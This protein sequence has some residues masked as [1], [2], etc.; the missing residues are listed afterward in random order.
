MQF[1]NVLLLLLRQDF[2]LFDFGY[3]P[4]SHI[5]CHAGG[6]CSIIAQRFAFI[7][8]V[9]AEV[10]GHD[11]WIVVPNRA[12]RLSHPKQSG[13]VQPGLPGPSSAIASGSSE[14]VH[15]TPYS[16]MQHWKGNE[17]VLSGAQYSSVS[18]VAACCCL[19]SS[20]LPQRMNSFSLST[21]NLVRLRR[22]L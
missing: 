9:Y 7:K 20:R 13:A 3:S 10:E 6:N 8:P 12:N 21:S 1:G 17:D 15:G 11:S 18:A 5:K 4:I 19:S 14:W 16:L 22:R 2:D